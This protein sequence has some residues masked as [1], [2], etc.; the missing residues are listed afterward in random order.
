[1]KR[2]RRFTFSVLCLVFTQLLASQPPEGFPDDTLALVAGKAITFA[3][4]NTQLNS[5]AVV[6]LSTPALGTPERGKVMFKLLENTI[7]HN[8]LYLDAIKQGR[9]G[10]TEYKRELRIFSDGLLARLYRNHYLGQGIQVSQH[11]IEDYATTHYFSDAGLTERLL[12]KIEEKLR[13]QKHTKR[14]QS[15]RQHLRHGVAVSIQPDNLDPQ[16]DSQRSHTEVVAEY[17]ERRITWGEV[18][19]RL[20]TLNSSAD[21]ERRLDALN[22]LIDKELMVIKARDTGLEKTPGYVKRM[23]DFSST[24]LVDT[25]RDKLIAD[26]QP[27][28]R[29]LRDYYEKNLDRIAFRAL[30]KQHA[31]F[32]DQETRKATRR[33]LL[34]ERLDQYVVRLRN[35]GYPVVVYKEN[36]NRLL[37]EEAHW[38]TARAKGMDANPRRSR[39]A[40]DSMA[41]M[42]D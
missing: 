31:S 1:M 13:K 37:R 3:Q 30:L 40:L 18:M 42:V 24:Q 28:E 39:E 5:S 17:G 20:T 12:Q 9:L 36:L 26:M 15:F 8:L 19:Q 38:I 34:K 32:E 23:A 7:S 21:M 27:S 22:S 16:K 10:D 25:H 29:E 35:T 6:G 41:S 14:Q 2:I 33:L 11:E 4:L